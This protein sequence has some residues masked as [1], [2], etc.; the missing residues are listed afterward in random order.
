[1]MGRWHAAWRLFPL[2]AGLALLLSACGRA[3]MSALNPQGP[4]AS[5]QLSLM[6]L[7]IAIMTLV[8]VVVFGISIY[9]VLRYR[10]R[11]GQDE[12]PKQVEGSHKL[13]V[14]WT[15]IPIILLIILAVPTVTYV[16]KFSKDYSNDADA[17]KIEVTG[18]QYWWR[19]KYPEY[20]IETAEDM[21]IPN[22]KKIALELK[23][24]DALHSFWVP[25]IA[26]KIDTNP[27]GNVNKMYI[28][29]Y[30]EGVYRGKCAEFCGYSHALMEFKVKSVSQKTFV[31]WVKEMKAAPKPFDNSLVAESFKQNCL[32]CHAIDNKSSS[33]PNLRGIG[34]RE[35]VAGILLNRDTIAEPLDQKKME[36]HL[37]MWIENPTKVKPGNGMPAFQGRLSEQELEGIVKYLASYK[38]DSLR[39]INK[40]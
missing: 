2:F 7:A 26:G 1:M 19:F 38:L 17:I 40:Q 29:T 34:S 27:S 35:A 3:D 28:E 31:A 36:E 12:I 13:E 16:F 21:I 20:D 33:G 18:H 23:T 9:V 5:E 14:I 25:S 30:K 39:P 15:V 24:A 8:V 11:Q 37:R 4:I 22:G 10:R 6:K 32:P